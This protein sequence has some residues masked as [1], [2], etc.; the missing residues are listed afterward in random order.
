M[1]ISLYKCDYRITET[2][3]ERKYTWESHKKWGMWD[4]ASVLSMKPL[5]ADVNATELFKTAGEKTIIV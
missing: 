5:C 4:D 1:L 2:F 3:V